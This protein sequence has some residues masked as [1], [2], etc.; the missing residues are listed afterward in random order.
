MPLVVRVVA[1]SSPPFPHRILMSLRSF[2]FVDVLAVAAIF[3]F[4]TKGCVQVFGDVML[5]SRATWFPNLLNLL[6]A[7]VQWTGR[8]AVF[9]FVITA[10]LEDEDDPCYRHRSRFHFY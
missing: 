6:C 9:L 4:S 5:T 1:T 3:R 2:L 7:S 8:I 10:V